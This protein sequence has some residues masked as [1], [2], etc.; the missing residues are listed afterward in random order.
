MAGQGTAALTAHGVTLVWHG[1]RANLTGLKGL[2]YFLHVGQEA[3]VGADLRRTIHRVNGER[4][5]LADVR[6]KYSRTANLTH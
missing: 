4:Q 3:Y 5:N 6:I 2:F 1:T